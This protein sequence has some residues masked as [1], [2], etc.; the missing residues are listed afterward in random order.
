MNTEPEDSRPFLTSTRRPAVVL[1]IVSVLAIT[2]VISAGLYGAKS[3]LPARETPEPP[4]QPGPANGGSVKALA[5]KYFRNWPA[6]QK[7][8]L[9]IV[10]SGQQHN[11]IQPCGCSRPLYG[12]LERRY[13]LMQSLRNSGIQVAAADLGDI[14]HAGRMREQDQMKYKVSMRAL[15]LMQY[16]ALGVGAHDFGYPLFDAMGETVLNEKYSF[17]VLASNLL[18]RD[19]QYPSE[20]GSTIGD[21]IMS[22]SNLKVGFTAVIGDSIQKKILADIKDPMAVKPEFGENLKVLPEM[23]KKL[24]DADIQ[25]LLYQGTYE[26]AKRIPQAIPQYNII[27]C[28]SEESEALSTPVLVDKTQIVRVGHKGR[29]V[30]V[31]SFFKKEGRYVAHYDRVELG[32]DLETARDDEAKNP[33]VQLMENYSKEVKSKDLL[34]KFAK[35]AALHPTQV[36]FPNE[37]AK[38]IYVGSDKCKDC[39][40]KDYEVWNDSKHAGAFEAL[41]TARKPSNRQYDPDCV[42]C[43]TIGYGNVSGYLNEEKTP[44]LKH[45]G[46]ESCHGPGGLHVAEPKNAKYYRSLSPWKRDAND[47]L[48]NAD[49]ETRIDL[50]TCQKCHDIDND[51]HFKFGKFWPDVAHGKGVRK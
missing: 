27:V 8:E 47:R 49:V 32:E 51:P 42:I 10:I 36:Q 9:V 30:G 16:D 45:V 44:H 15:S 41:E 18:K 22:R 33:V 3:H 20:N 48:P 50:Q 4:P 1:T 46:C 21:V 34:G 13:D 38:P 37:K 40:E 43:H 6:D 7:P 5:E 25:L 26:D 35:M 23:L 14:Y 28:L 19:E 12:G 29:A 11:F 24:K 31:M 17:R 39:H 2:A